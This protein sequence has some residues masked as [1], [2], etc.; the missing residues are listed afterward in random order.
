MTRNFYDQASRYAA[1]LDPVG[2][3]T[4]LLRVDV[5]FQSW[6]DTRRLPFPGEPDRVCDTVAAL[7][8]PAVPGVPW[9]V[10]V[11]FQ[12]EPRE[13]L[14][15]RLLVYLGQLWLEERPSA[16]R[17]DR[18]QVGA[19]VV[20]LTGQGHTSHDMMFA[21]VMRTNLLVAERDLATEDAA[22]VL[23]GI[24]AGTLARCLLPF[25]PL[26]QR[27][28]EAGIIQQWLQLASAEMDARLRGDYGGLAIVL[29][30]A[31]GRRDVW[32]QAL[33][34]WNVTQSQQVLEW[35]AEGEVKGEVKGR[36]AT[37]LR[38]LRARFGILPTDLETAIRAASDLSILDR[39]TDAAATA[40]TLQDF[41]QSARV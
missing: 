22:A 10:P 6:L 17:G 12:L 28:G 29:A 41:R 36:V 13:E 37:L 27:G 4:W 1:K 25:V 38:V 16:K 3:L 33:R 14:F 20:N 24:A 35:M 39:W 34:G 21:S 32:T 26:M 15:G 5:S 2:F 40:L 9:A 18:Y 23:A 8:D 11:E 7:E 19:V 30:E 31:A